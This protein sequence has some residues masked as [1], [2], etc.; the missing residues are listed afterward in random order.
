MHKKEGISGLLLLILVLAPINIVQ[1]A[2]PFEQ[3]CPKCSGIGTI[4][5]NSTVTCPTCQG[6]GNLTTLINCIKCNGTGRASISTPCSVCG[7]SGKINPTITTK[8]TSNH[9]V[10]TDY[11]N[12]I[13]RCEI[14]LKNE[15][16]QTT[17]CFAESKIHVT[18]SFGDGTVADFTSQSARTLLSPHTDTTVTVDTIVTG[19]VFCTF[20]YQVYLKSFD[21]INCPDCKGVGGFSSTVT[22]DKCNGTGT[23][24]VNGICPDCNGTRTITTLENL[25]CPECNGTGQITNLTNTLFLGVGIVAIVA[26]GSIGA[27]MWHKKKTAH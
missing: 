1:A 19:R 21:Q 20:T 16:D 5:H 27:F 24:M 18:S 25:S 11:T 3:V 9:D 15:A 23:V 7:G 8:S 2:G 17:Y 12:S 22:C 10:S 26:V 13:L 14:V 6:A 4:P